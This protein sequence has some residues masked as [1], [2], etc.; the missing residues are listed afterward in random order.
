MN[1]CQAMLRDR[2]IGN[3]TLLEAAT[4]LD[5][6]THALANVLHKPCQGIF[7]TIHPIF[8]DIDWSLSRPRSEAQPRTLDQAH[9]AFVALVVRFGFNTVVGGCL[10]QQPTLLL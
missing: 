8:V 1:R 10:V 3:R 7:L 2:S 9:G 4:A 5:K 6:E